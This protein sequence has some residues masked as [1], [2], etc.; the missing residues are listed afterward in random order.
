M[1]RTAILSDCGKFRYR[2]GRRWHSGPTLLFVMLNPS[3]ANAHIDDPTIK[4]CMGFAA[5]TG[6]SAIEV[7]NLFAYRATHPRDL[8]LAGWP[9]GPDNQCH[10]ESTAAEVVAVGGK[11][12]CAWGS[13]ARGRPEAEAMV[14]ALTVFGG[15]SVYALS[16][17]ADGT[18]AHPLMLPYSCQLEVF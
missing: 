3:V 16:R 7:V 9:V 2:L 15:H 8:K 18:P 12:V 1:Q 5:R 4:K 10:V 11:I 17:L 14:T 13:N 6:H